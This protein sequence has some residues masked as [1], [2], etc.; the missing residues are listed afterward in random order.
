[1]YI[2]SSD[3]IW[4]RVLQEGEDGHGNQ[5]HIDFCSSHDISRA[6]GI[7]WTYNLSVKIKYSTIFRESLAK[8]LAKEGLP[9]K[10]R[11]PKLWT[12]YV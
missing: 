6:L 8:I 5:K 2:V 4:K 10:A 3:Y 1:M 11:W 7:L 9:L 12:C